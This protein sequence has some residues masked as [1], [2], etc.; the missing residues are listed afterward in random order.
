GTIRLDTLARI[1][2]KTLI[3]IPG[4]MLYPL[5]DLLWKLHA[6]FIEGPSAALDGIRY[7]WVV[8]DQKT[9]KTLGLG[10]RCS[11]AEV[12]R[13]LPGNRIFQREHG[14][15]NERSVR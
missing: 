15:S 9:R 10:P 13:L 1:L 14:A 3:G 7:P 6:P 11:V 12:I 8:D 2:G 4:C 5:V